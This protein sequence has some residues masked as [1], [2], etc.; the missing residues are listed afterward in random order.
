MGNE[1]TQSAVH[2]LPMSCNL[3][4]GLSGLAPLAIGP[5]GPVDRLRRRRLG[6]SWGFLVVLRVLGGQTSRSRP[7]TLTNERR[8]RPNKTKQLYPFVVVKLVHWA[9]VTGSRVTVE[10][11]GSRL[12]AAF[13]EPKRLGFFSNSL[14]FSLPSSRGVVKVDGI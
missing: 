4:N 13:F 10:A 5:V 1:H 9:L 6:G 8:A 14:S 11:M 12:M 2:L 7:S 3:A